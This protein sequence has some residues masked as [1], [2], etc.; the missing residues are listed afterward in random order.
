MRLIAVLILL[1]WS[2]APGGARGE[3][4]DDVAAPAQVRQLLKLLAEP[5][6]RTWLEEELKKVR[7]A[8]IKRPPGDFGG[9]ACGRAAGRRA[10]PP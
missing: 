1:L 4:G 5:A 9:P 10:D 2:G 8:S 7:T 3:T 6:V